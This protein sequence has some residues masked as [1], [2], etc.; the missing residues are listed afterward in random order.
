MLI[1]QHVELLLLDTR[2]GYLGRC[3]VKWLKSRLTSSTA[4]WKIVLSGSSF[5]RI[6]VKDEGNAIEVVDNQSKRC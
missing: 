4:T 3:Q 6:D 2:R 5:G 1:G